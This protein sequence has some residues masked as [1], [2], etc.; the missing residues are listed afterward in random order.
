MILSLRL[1]LP[2][3]IKA[4]FLDRTDI[5]KYVRYLLPFQP[6]CIE[7]FKLEHGGANLLKTVTDEDHLSEA[8]VKDALGGLTEVDL[9]KL[10][11]IANRLSGGAVNAD[12]LFQDTMLA[13]LGG[14][15][16]QK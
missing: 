2:T 9:A 13:A 11:M 6:I 10:K 4:E 8:E 15:E 16:D 1:K 5:K 14:Y 12:D 3:L 7:A